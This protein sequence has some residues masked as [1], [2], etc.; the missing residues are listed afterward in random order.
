MD[1]GSE[2]L[3]TLIG[4]LVSS[5]Q[6]PDRR[7]LQRALEDVL[8]TSNALLA[9]VQPLELTVGDEFQGSFRTVSAAARAS[10]LLRLELL[11]REGGSDSRYGL[12][13]GAITV[14]DGS[15]SPASQDGPGWWSARTA[16]DRAKRLADSPRTSYARTCFSYWPPETTANLDAAAIEAFLIC[17]DATLDRMNKRGQR[18]LLGLLLGRTQAQLAAE[19]GVTQGAVS[20]HLRRSGAFAIHAAQLRL[21]EA[22][23]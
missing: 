2:P 1:L 22:L 13:H 14:F 17:R 18:F 11:L 21:E 20:Q 15:R 23:T 10:L 9:P 7:K 12:G 16:I 5:R 19:E 6:N 3:A 8:R 4:D